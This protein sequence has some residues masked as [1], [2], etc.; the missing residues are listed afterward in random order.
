MDNPI[1][2]QAIQAISIYIRDDIMP[3]FAKACTMKPD[4]IWS[5]RNK[6]HQ[7]RY[8]LI[9]LKLNSNAALNE[10]QA[11]LDL[12]KNLW[13]LVLEDQAN[14]RESQEYKKAR[15]M[16]AKAEVITQ[17]EEFLSGEDTLKDVLINSFAFNL[18]WKANTVWVDSAKRA[19]KTSVKNYTI[20]LQDQIWS[21]I[22]ES[23]S[24]N[25]TLQKSVEVG[26]RLEAIIQIISSEQLSA[27]LQVALACRIYLAL[28]QLRMGLLLHI[29]Q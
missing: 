29:F 27:D 7:L 26:K 22:S 15:T 18:N 25:A 6:I 9:K 20:D 11:M 13:Q 19:H 28:I 16:N 2:G 12:S 17:I 3:S 1:S 21:F 8:H 23:A 24:E 10:I 14:A 4:E 5:F